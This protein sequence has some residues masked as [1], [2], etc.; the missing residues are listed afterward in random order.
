MHDFG[1]LTP[2]LVPPGCYMRS[3]GTHV[4]HIAFAFAFYHWWTVGGQPLAIRPWRCL[5]IVSHLLSWYKALEF[6]LLI[7]W[8]LRPDIA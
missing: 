3:Y 2:G 1:L 4:V 7:F 5:A 8:S 6:Y